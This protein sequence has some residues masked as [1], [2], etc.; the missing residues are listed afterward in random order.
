MKASDVE[1]IVSDAIDSRLMSHFESSF[2][3]NNFEYSE[4]SHIGA[5]DDFKGDLEDPRRTHHSKTV[6][7]V[8]FTHGSNLEG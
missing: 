1:I 3:L 8:S 4:K 2:R 6:G 7:S 5:E